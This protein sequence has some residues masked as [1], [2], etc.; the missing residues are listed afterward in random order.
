MS[1]NISNLL[2]KEGLD[3][4]ANAAFVK[5]SGWV[6]QETGVELKENMT[7]EEL[8][9]LKQF[10]TDNEADLLKMKVADRAS[11]DDNA[12]SKEN[13]SADRLSAREMQLTLMQ[14]TENRLAQNFIYYFAMWW[15]IVVAVYIFAV[16]FFPIGKENLRLADTILGFMLGTL[17]ATIIQF[18]YGSSSSSRKK[19]DT[20]ADA[21]KD[22]KGE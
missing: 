6:K 11:S 1:D 10:E 4:L 15:G 20:I 9:K 3:L 13:E 5:G 12:E 22:K 21:L 7:P 17:V 2:S 8:C 19:D 14:K 18:F 16:T